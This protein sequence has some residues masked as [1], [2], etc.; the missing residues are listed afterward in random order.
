MH[1]VFYVTIKQEEIVLLHAYK[2]QGQKLPLR[3]R[4]VALR[5]MKEIL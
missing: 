1:R 4:E 2:K 5:R 3:E